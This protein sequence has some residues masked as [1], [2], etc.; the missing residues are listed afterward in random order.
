MASVLLVGA[1]VRGREAT[2]ACMGSLVA[3]STAL[4]ERKTAGTPLQL[5]MSA[6]I[7]WQAERAQQTASRDV[8][9]ACPRRWAETPVCSMPGD[10]RAVAGSS[11]ELWSS[12]VTA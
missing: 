12:T 11:L 2:G 7:T 1:A 8:K 5:L 10:V 3:L 9:A 6:S 4:H